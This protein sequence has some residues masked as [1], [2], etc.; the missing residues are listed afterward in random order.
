MNRKN[1]N[2]V[3]EATVKS[4]NQSTG[5]THLMSLNDSELQILSKLTK[6]IL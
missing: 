2:T 5:D 6:S 3:A 4:T 1:T